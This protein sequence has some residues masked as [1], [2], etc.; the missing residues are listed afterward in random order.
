MDIVPLRSRIPDHVRRMGQ[1]QQWLA[2]QLDMSRQQL[3]DY[4]TL[5][6]LLGI[7][8]AR[9]IAILLGVHIDDLYEWG[10]RGE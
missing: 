10:R 6:H 5:R 2:D 8:K 1:T 9:E 3:S 7:I 4:V